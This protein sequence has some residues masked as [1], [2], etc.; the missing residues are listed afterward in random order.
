MNS[1]KIIFFVIKDSLRI[2]FENKWLY[3][4]IG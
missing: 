1:N 3:N 4:F 2:D